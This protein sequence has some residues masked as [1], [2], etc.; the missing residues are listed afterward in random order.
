MQRSMSQVCGTSVK[1][2]TSSLGL[3]IPPPPRFDSHAY[4]ANSNNSD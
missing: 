4:L 2:D 1:I 3:Y